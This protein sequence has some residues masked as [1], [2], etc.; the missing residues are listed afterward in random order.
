MKFQ[1]SDYDF[2]KQCNT[3]HPLT[4]EYWSFDKHDRYRCKAVGKAYLKYRKSAEYKPI[5]RKYKQIVKQ[6]Q[7]KTP[8]GVAYRIFTS[9]R[10][11]DKQCGRYQ[12]K[13]F[14]TTEWVLSQVE[15]PDLKCHYCSRAMA[16]GEGINRGL[17]IGLDGHYNG[18]TIERLDNDLC[19]LQSNCVF[20]CRGC[21]GINHPIR[22]FN[23]DKFNNYFC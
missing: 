6:M 13:D 17:H 16:F 5:K 11:T 7:M 14:I 19:H 20:A 4:K 10:G 21:Q 15:N 2:C 8:L 9:S 1:T 12:E 3:N 23:L 18:L 22:K